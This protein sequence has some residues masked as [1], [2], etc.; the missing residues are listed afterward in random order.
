METQTEIEQKADKKSNKLFPIIFGAIIILGATF[1]IIKY[2]HS[3]HYQDTDDAQ[4]E[5]DISPIIPKVSGYVDAIR[6]TDNQTVK[7]GDTLVILDARDYELRVEQAEAAYENALANLEVV[8]AGVNASQAGVTTAQANIGT[9]EANIEAAKVKLWQADQDFKRYSNLIE[10][11]SITQQQFEQ[12]KAAKESAEKQLEVWQR[13]KT[14]ASEQRKANVSQTAVSSGNV[15]VAETNV[16][17]RKSEL[18][19]AKLQLSYTVLTAPID[20]VVSRKNI[21]VGQLVQAG[22]S[23]FA[24]VEQSDLW[25]VANFKETELNKMQAGQEVEI[26]VDAYPGVEYRGRV[27]SFSAAT[28]A[29][30][31][32]LPPDNATGNFVKVVQRVPVKIVFNDDQQN[33]ERLR[34]GMNVEVEVHLN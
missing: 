12:A 34:A 33:L 7:K 27:E 17:M 15:S 24:I 14:V 21:E 16:K 23:L 3:L 32:L 4:I 10:D 18:D 2:I 31:S 26:S 6:I 30:F 28:G 11:H 22:Q 20:G 9:V 13:Q 19:M 8:K 25:V 5:S 1:G 29:K